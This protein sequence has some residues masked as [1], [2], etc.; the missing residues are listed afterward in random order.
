MDEPLETRY[1]FMMMLS[2]SNQDG[3]VEG[4][5]ASVAR[6]F[7][8]PLGDFQRALKPLLEPDR[9]S[10]TPDDDGVRIV[11]VADT[12]GFSVVNYR[13]Y[14]QIRDENHRRIYNKALQLLRAQRERE[15]LDT[16]GTTYDSRFVKL[17]SNDF[18][19][20]DGTFPPYSELT[21]EEI[22]SAAKAKSVAVSE[23]R[24]RTRRKGRNLRDNSP[25]L[26]TEH[27]KGISAAQGVIRRDEYEGG[28]F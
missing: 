13:A 4:T 23:E 10:N 18:K 12:H 19:G 6:K 24:R 26:S 11:R 17:V 7:N 2:Q 27:L 15:G 20:F 28:N 22:E 21:K 1:V 3:V 25:P 9:F 5:D 8:M 16:K 14:A